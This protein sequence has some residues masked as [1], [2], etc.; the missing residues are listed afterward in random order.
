MSKHRSLLTLGGFLVSMLALCLVLWQPL[1]QAVADPIAFRAW[2]GEHQGISRLTMAGLMALQ[3]VIAFLPGEPLEIAAGYA[4]GAWEGMLLCLLGATAGCLITA[5]LARRYGRRI[6][7]AFFPPEKI[8][9][10][11]LLHEPR[12][13]TLLVFLL[14]LIPGSP[15]DLF[16]YAIGLTRLPLPRTLLITAVARIPSILTSTLS[17]S[18]LG[19]QNWEQAALYL[20][21]TLLL[22]GV[23]LLIYRRMIKKGG[24]ASS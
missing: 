12:R 13:L 9:A 11:P 8:D 3:V 2:V 15:K 23:G 1:T 10:L 5:P 7:E 16:N 20:A 6:L 24:T 21:L 22:S 4:F 19:S 18:A 17:G 14:Y